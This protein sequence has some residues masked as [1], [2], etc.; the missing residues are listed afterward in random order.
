MAIPKIIHFCWFSGDK[1]PHLIKQC[2]KSWEKTLPD[3]E[4]KLWD[5]NSFDFESVPFVKQAFENKQWAFVSDYVRLYALYNYG[6]VYLDSDVLVKQRFDEWHDYKFFTG[7]ETR[8]PQH[9]QF[10]IEAA[11][12]GSEQNNPIIKEAMKYYEK[13]NFIKEDGSFDKTPAPDIITDIFIKNYGWERREGQQNFKDGTVIFSHND[14]T[15]SQYPL[16]PSVRLYHCN[17][18]SWIPTEEWRS[19]L[20]KFCR[21]HDLMRYYKKFEKISHW[22]T[23]K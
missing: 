2:L 3:Y 14:I 5:D 6:G 22:L 8:N 1:Y 18:C 20:Y 17:N 19:P 9:S 15:S 7:I 21:K 13:R 23:R 11:I 10:W 16:K 4:I 12:M